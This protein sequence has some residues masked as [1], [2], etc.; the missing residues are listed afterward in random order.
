MTDVGRGRYANSIRQARL[1]AGMSRRDLARLVRR[2]VS[3]IGDYE[4]GWVEPPS[5]IVAAIGDVTGFSPLPP[6]PAVEDCE[7][8]KG[9]GWLWQATSETDPMTRTRC[10]NCGGR[11][12]VASVH[13]GDA[14]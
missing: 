7:T 1:L 14:G 5:S 11:L 6:S 10:H 9:H 2:S 3:V 4:N 12:S 8:C 13:N